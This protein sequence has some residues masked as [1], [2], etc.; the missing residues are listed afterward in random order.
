MLTN[1]YH[2]NDFKKHLQTI[3]RQIVPHNARR[4]LTENLSQTLLRNYRIMN[5][6]KHNA[7]KLLSKK[8]FQCLQIIEKET[9]PNNAS[10]LLSE[11]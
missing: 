1:H 11:N 6:S 10:K 3:I 8:S 9:I 7:Y 5:H 4:L 2:K